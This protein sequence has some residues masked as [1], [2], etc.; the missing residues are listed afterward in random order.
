MTHEHYVLCIYIA[1]DGTSPDIV[2]RMA[3]A[4]QVCPASDGRG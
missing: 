2:L 4:D 1:E 3:H